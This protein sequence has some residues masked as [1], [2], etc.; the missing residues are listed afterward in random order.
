MTNIKNENIKDRIKFLRKEK[1]N[2][3]QIEFG[4]KLGSAGST[5]VGW[6][7]GDRIPPESTIKLICNEFNVNYAWLKDGVGDIFSETNK[8]LIDLLCEENEL[9]DIQRRIIEAVIE[10]SD[11]EIN[12]FTMRFFGYKAIEK[13]D[14]K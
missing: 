10:L 14:H 6:E 1:L 4:K 5:V 13:D 2:L 9:N 3:T 12:A 8:S 11:D 7:K